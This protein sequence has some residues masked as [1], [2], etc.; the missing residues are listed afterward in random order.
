LKEIEQYAHFP[1]LPAGMY[2]FEWHA[3][4]WA[5]APGLPVQF[6]PGAVMTFI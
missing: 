3:G 5:M 6:I 1:N 2:L 4:H